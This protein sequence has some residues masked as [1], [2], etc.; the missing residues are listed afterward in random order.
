M[1]GLLAVV[2]PL[3]LALP[4]AYEERAWHG[5]RWR[6][7]TRTFAHLL[8][9][10]GGHPPSYARV[11]G[12]DGPATV[13]TFH[14]SGAELA[15]LQHSGP[16]FFG[17]PW[18]PQIVGLVLDPGPEVDPEEL[19]ELLTESYRLLAPRKLADGV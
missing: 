2:R 18:G 1:D 3:C 10:E 16:R 13:L 14:S 9:I 11:A 6:I 4:E 7:R 8:P 12:T 17:A 15:A 5:V 19:T